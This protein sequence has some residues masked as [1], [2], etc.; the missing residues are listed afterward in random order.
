MN[1]RRQ[2]NLIHNLVHSISQ[3]FRRRTIIV[4]CDQSI[5]QYALGGKTQAIV[6]VSMIGAFCWIS[7]STGSYM[8]SQSV[9]EQKDRQLESTTMKTRQIG[10][11]Y[12]LLKRDLMKLK[13]N[14]GE[15]GEYAQFVLKQHTLDK[16]F[17]IPDLMEVDSHDEDEEVSGE[18][19]E[20][21]MSRVDFLEERISKLQEENQQIVE[22][23]QVRTKGKIRELTDVIKIA[24]F[25][26]ERMKAAARRTLPKDELVTA[27]NLKAQGGP[28]FP[29]K[30]GRSIEG[31]IEQMMLLDSIVAR[32][33]LGVPMRGAKITSGFGRRL[34]PFNRRWAMH[35][36][37]DFSL[38]SGA[39]VFATNEGVVKFAGWQ[40]AYGNQIE[41]THGLGLATRYAHLSKVAV[42]PGQRIKEGTLIGYE[43]STGRS[44]G[45]HLHYEVYFN[46]RPLNPA[47]FVKAGYYVQKQKS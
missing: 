20:R 40:N 37:M 42:R 47:N 35:T 22:A 33:P 11:E 12:S 6:L 5:D 29:E 30:L 41:I 36:G 19:H 23:V 14:K 46:G 15:L 18:A 31:N 1:S 8:A 32:M 39:P 38:S 24:G 44:T 4:T 21:L 25:N 16:E 17:S 28:Y 10:E 2:K 43:G 13:E 26:P 34:D 9:M 27:E 3:I 45:A 7:Y